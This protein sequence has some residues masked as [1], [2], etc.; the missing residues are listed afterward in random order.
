VVETASYSTGRAT[1]SL[2]LSLL[3]FLAHLAFCDERQWVLTI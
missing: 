2:H 3:F 1:T